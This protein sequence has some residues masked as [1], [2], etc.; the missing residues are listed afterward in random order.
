MRVER[1]TFDGDIRVFGAA[2]I[3]FDDITV[4]TTRGPGMIFQAGVQPGCGI[5]A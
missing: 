2:H 3:V 5:L 1:L 4:Q